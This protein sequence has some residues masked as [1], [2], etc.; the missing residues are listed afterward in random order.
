MTS[1]CSRWANVRHCAFLPLLLLGGIGACGGGTRPTPSAED[2][3]SV[4]AAP[5]APSASA[6][7]SADSVGGDSAQSERPEPPV[8]ILGQMPSDE[9][10]CF[11]T[12]P[13]HC[14]DGGGPPIPEDRTDLSDPTFTPFTVAPE[15]LNRDDIEL[16][17]EREYSP[18][19]REAGVGGI[20]R[21]YCRISERG[22]VEDVRIS[23]SS[24]HPDLDNAGLKVARVMRFTPAMN[25]GEP[26]TIWVA[27]PIAFRPD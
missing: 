23:Q 16:A 25:L 12:L 18:L 13:I 2:T 14:P 7:S 9:A 26:V 5:A 21:V 6:S 11:P 8:V 27:L 15:I 24:G 10:V 17:R 20:V 22:I 3:Q 1:R 19:L 4:S